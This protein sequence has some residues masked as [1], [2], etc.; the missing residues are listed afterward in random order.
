MSWCA[1]SSVR[2]HA[3][4]VRRRRHQLLVPLSTLRIPPPLLTDRGGQGQ[5]ARPSVAAQP[6]LPA[7]EWGQGHQ[8]RDQHR[9]AQDEK[10]Q[11]AGGRG[12][13]R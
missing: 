11:P 4:F 10:H 8:A 9:R 13:Q 2:V 1:V 12:S 6:Q 3:S 7:A 5:A